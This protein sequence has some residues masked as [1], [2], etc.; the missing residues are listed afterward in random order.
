MFGF[1][2]S[3][4]RRGRWESGKAGRRGKGK[5]TDSGG[6]EEEE[7]QGVLLV[8]PTVLLPPDGWVHNRNA[9]TTTKTGTQAHVETFA[10]GD[11]CLCVFVFLTQK[12]FRQD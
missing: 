12:T 9:S 2:S 5:P 6:A 11:I 7:D 10:H 3:A 8:V 4:K 1:P